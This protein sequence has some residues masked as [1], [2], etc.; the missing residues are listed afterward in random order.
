L[1][2]LLEAAKAVPGHKRKSTPV[3]LEK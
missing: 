2:P 1:F 3:T